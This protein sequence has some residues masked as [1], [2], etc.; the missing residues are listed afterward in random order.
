MAGD[1]L[2]GFIVL[3]LKSG[4][5]DDTF[6]LQTLS[7]LKIKFKTVLKKEKFKKKEEKEE[8]EGEEEEEL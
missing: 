5:C 7:V 2:V 3:A 1:S 6:S 8:E 4:L